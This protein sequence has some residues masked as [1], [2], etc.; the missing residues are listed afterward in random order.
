MFCRKCGYELPEDSAFCP[1]CGTKAYDPPTEM[2]PEPVQSK[3]EPK[4]EQLQSVKEKAVPT[5]QAGDI[6]I[7]LPFI[8][9]LILAAIIIF[10]ASYMQKKETPEEPELPVVED[11]EEKAAAEDSVVRLFCFDKDGKKCAGGSGFAVYEDG[12]IVTNYHLI[13]QGVFRVIA[14][15]ENQV[16]ECST[17]LAF[18]PENDIAFLKTDRDMKLPLLT[19]N[20][21]GAEEG[22][23]VRFVERT[24]EVKPVDFSGE[25]KGYITDGDRTLF[26]YS[27]ASSP[28]G[29]GGALLNEAGEV[30]GI[31]VSSLGDGEVLNNA[32]PSVFVDLMYYLMKPSDAMS[33]EAFYEK[34]G[35][36]YSLPTYTVGYL[37]EHYEELDGEEMHLE[38][39]ASTIYMREIMGERDLNATVLY[40]VDEKEAIRDRTIKGYTHYDFS[41]E[42]ET[43]SQENADV[44]SFSSVRLYFNKEILDW[45]Q[46]GDKVSILCQFRIQEQIEDYTYKEGY[47]LFFTPYEIRVIK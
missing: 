7:L 38:G 36:V 10:V 14:R 37:L 42:A 44:F 18:D 25:Y 20:T 41:R 35:R 24:P 43:L 17:V 13:E 47:K 40:L 33:L 5:K 15:T 46:P 23:T 22:E 26:Q 1:K 29:D 12:I 45:I 31:G 28:A 6:T 32:V 4:A 3:P 34:Y 30:I 27:A 21:E 2:I 16:S 8:G 19:V 11:V 39:Y 9:V